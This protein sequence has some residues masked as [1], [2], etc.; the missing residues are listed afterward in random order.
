MI[1]TI[2]YYIDIAFVVV[3]ALGFIIARFF[4]SIRLKLLEL[5]KSIK[6]KGNK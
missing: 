1:W 4:P 3:F 2:V 5:V 6:E